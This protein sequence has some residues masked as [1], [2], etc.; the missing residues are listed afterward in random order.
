MMWPF[1]RHHQITVNVAADHELRADVDEIRSSLRGLLRVWQT[2]DR[3]VN[4]IMATLADFEAKFAELDAATTAIANELAALK[5]QL[6]NA[7]L[8]A[9]VEASVLAT[10]TAKVDA[11]KSLASVSP[12]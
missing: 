2:I 9:D 4:D 8:P 3:K 1:T 12:A 10:L 6:T 5:D 11:L 7:G